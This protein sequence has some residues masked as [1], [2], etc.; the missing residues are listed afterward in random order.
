[1]TKY[2]RSLLEYIVL[3]ICGSFDGMKRFVWIRHVGGW[4]TSNFNIISIGLTVLIGDGHLDASVVRMDTPEQPVAESAP[5]CK[6]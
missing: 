6:K 5:K 1:M 3:N 2:V 4:V